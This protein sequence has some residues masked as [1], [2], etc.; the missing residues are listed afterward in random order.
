V[1]VGKW[2]LAQ[3]EHNTASKRSARSQQ[4][5]LKPNKW[6]GL[7]VPNLSN[8]IY[9]HHPPTA[10]IL[11]QP[12]LRKLALL[13]AELTSLAMVV[14]LGAAAVSSSKAGRCLRSP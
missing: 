12:L 8:N 11:S 5:T 14:A 4:E 3:K 2:L 1:P 13:M 6:V 9:P 7:A 10:L